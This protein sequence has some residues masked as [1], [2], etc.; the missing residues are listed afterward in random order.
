MPPE[1]QVA[2]VFLVLERAVSRSYKQCVILV[3][4]NSHTRIGNEYRKLRTI[5]S[6]DSVAK[7][8]ILI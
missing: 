4:H 5:I 7:I 8:H 2:R 1:V 3:I 6:T